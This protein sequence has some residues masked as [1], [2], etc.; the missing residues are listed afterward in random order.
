MGIGEMKKAVFLDRDG[1]LNKAII[2]D[3]KPYPPYSLAQ[4]QIPADA[5]TALQQ[6]KQAGFMLIGVTNQPDV[7]RGKTSRDLVEAINKEL[8]QALPLDE[9]HVCYHDN[10]DKC[11]CRKPEPG[12]LLDAAKNH[13][14][15]LSQSFMIGDRAKDIEAGLRANCKTIWLNGNYEEEKPQQYDYQVNSLMQAADWIIKEHDL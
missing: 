10:A 11:H 4:L 3:G 5:A 14:I 7:A 13:D 2:V 1:V 15:D 6:L 9:I 8:M 12:F